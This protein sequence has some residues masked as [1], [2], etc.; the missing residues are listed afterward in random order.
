MRLKMANQGCRLAIRLLPDSNETRRQALK[1]L[2][3]KYRQQDEYRKE[4]RELQPLDRTALMPKD[5]AGL[6]PE[7]LRS[8]V[9]SGVRDWQ[10]YDLAK[11]ELDA[12]YPDR[13]YRK[14]T[15][16]KIEKTV[17]EEAPKERKLI[18]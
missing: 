14:P 8:E 2:M 10:A 5:T 16:A 17:T 9:A 3:E 11:K 15:E 1:E 7:I 12:K 13:I 18:F 4:S 6:S